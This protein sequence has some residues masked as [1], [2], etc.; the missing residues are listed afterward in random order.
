MINKQNEVNFTEI[1]RATV[2]N[3]S[4]EDDRGSF[5]AIL[6]DTGE[7][8]SVTYVS[9]YAGPGKEGFIAVPQHQQKILVCR[10]SG[11]KEWFYLGAT[12]EPLEVDSSEEVAESVEKPAVKTRSGSIV[13]D[14]DGNPVVVRSKK[15]SKVQQAQELIG[16]IN[17]EPASKDTAKSVFES[18][19][20]NTTATSNVPDKILL[21]GTHGQGLE[22]SD[23]KNGKTVMNVKTE[24]T[25]SNG[26]KVTMHDSPGIDSIK[27]DSGN[28]ASITLTQNPQNNPEKSAASIEIDCNGPQ[29]HVCRES[30]LEMKVLGG[31]RELNITNS[32]NGVIWA[33][34]QHQNPINPCGNVNIQSDWGDVN[35]MSRSQFTGRIFIET[36]NP[37]GTSQLIQLATNGPNGTIVLKSNRILLDAL[38]TIEMSAPGGIYMNAGAGGVHT[39]T[40]GPVLTQAGTGVNIDPGGGVVNLAPGTAGAVP[41]P[42]IPLRTRTPYIDPAA[43]SVVQNQ[44]DYAFRGVE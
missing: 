7:D 34:Y 6:T 3:R 29:L 2:E 5:Q 17:I 37:A 16:D 8:I 18:T 43:P 32:A 22:I 19:E 36:V 31:G 40:A 14:R 10:P 35:I 11:S 39:N 27:I 9:P 23:S 24:L 42:N 1:R 28:N 44:S 12:F 38:E 30:D 21:K 25:S 41:P 13:R 33:N 20:G 26:K 4:S 15:K